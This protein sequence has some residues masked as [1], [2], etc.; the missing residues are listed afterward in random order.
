MRRPARQTLH[1]DEIDATDRA[2]LGPL[3]YDIFRESYGDLDR[4][5]VC[6][7]IV[8]R[9]GGR[10]HL[11]RDE[12]GTLVGFVTTAIGTVEVSGRRHEV[13]S[14]G[15]YFQRGIRAG[16]MAAR[17]ALLD[18]VQHKLR[19]PWRS[20]AYVVELLTPVSYRRAVRTVGRLFPS[21]RYPLPPERAAVLRA[22]LHQRGLLVDDER[23]YVARY[24]D[25]ASHRAPARILE[26]E[27]L[28][29]DPDVRFYLEHNPGFTEGDILCALAPF[30]WRD[31][32]S[33]FLKPLTSSF[34]RSPR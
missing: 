19:H 24:P 12:A 22:T 9:E 30:D 21:R 33:T 7:E 6:D 5:T 8:F 31:I 4:A 32:A 20:Y 17:R 25:P 27:R 18:L 11:Y 28:R 34:R 15:A 1:V 29:A 2:R 3:L 23:P 16:A 14:T 26:S 10:L 13:M